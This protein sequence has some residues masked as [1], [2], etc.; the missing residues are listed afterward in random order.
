MI[1]V[2]VLGAAADFTY[3]LKWEMVSLHIML[4]Y[5]HLP[6]SFKAWIDLKASREWFLWYSFP[7]GF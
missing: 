3:S 5:R 6:S 2:R 1:R 7:L 4:Y